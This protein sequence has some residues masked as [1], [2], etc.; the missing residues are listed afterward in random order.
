[1]TAFKEN[2]LISILLMNFMKKLHENIEP[3]VT[4]VIVVHEQKPKR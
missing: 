4:G 1:M 2:L 3:A